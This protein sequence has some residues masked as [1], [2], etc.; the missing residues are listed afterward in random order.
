MDTAVRDDNMQ[1]DDFAAEYRNLLESGKHGA[2][3]A[4]CMSLYNND[5]TDNTLCF[6][7]KSDGKYYEKGSGSGSTEVT[8]IKNPLD[9]T[10]I[11]ATDISGL[12]PG[13]QIKFSD[14]RDHRD[15]SSYNFDHTTFVDDWFD[16]R[17]SFGEISKDAD[18][19]IDVLG[20]EMLQKYKDE[21]DDTIYDK[22]KNL[23]KK[24][25]NLDNKMRDLYG[26][27]GDVDL[28]LDSSVYSTMLFTV[29]T[30]SLLYYLFIKM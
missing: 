29:M 7:K 28:N 20:S 30:T 6:H 9:D 24:R 18:G 17:T 1:L 27:T 23:L 16:L 11:T 26:E 12:Y 2:L 5:V 8:D 4:K 21:Y 19:N 10:V 22:H 3:L 13:S 15:M 14:I 25:N